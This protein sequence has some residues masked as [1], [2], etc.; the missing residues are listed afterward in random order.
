MEDYAALLTDRTVLP[1][2]TTPYTTCR[3]SSVAAR[4]KKLPPQTVAVFLMGL[5]ATESA[6]VQSITAATGARP[7]V[8]ETDALTAAVAAAAVT[9]LRAK[10]I[11]PRQ[12]RLAVIGADRAPLLESV[13]YECGA[14]H[15]T[16]IHSE[17]LLGPAIRKLMVVHDI[18]VDLTGRDSMWAV[19][20]RT[21][22]VP[23]D[24]FGF[25]AL[26]LPGL[27]SALCGHGASS[28]TIHALAAAA[29]ALALITPVDRALPDGRDHRLVP[30]VARQV[31]R[32]LGAPAAG[33]P[34]SR[35]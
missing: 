8:S 35:P 7:V 5:N 33:R 31:S 28:V 4:I 12:G 17:M 1:A 15:V 18:M 25:A 10:R 11:P 21:V 23:A 19:P 16:A 32:V 27:L 14:A 3:P 34:Q 13:L 2:T 9:A 20:T 24:P 22:A 26:A 6:A 30:V 29:R